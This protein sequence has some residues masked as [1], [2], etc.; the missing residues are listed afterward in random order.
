MART[1]LRYHTN[2]LWQ[3]AL[4]SSPM[5]GR[6]KREL[7]ANLLHRS[8]ALRV[9]ESLRFTDSL[10]VLNYHRVLDPRDCRYDRAVISASPDQFHEQIS[11]F[12]SRF[13]VIGL[14][15]L[16][17]QVESGKPAVGFRTMITFD[18][19][20]VD[21]YRNAF[22]VL[23]AA[24]LPA[25]FFLTTSYIGTSIVPWW[26]Q[27]ADLLRRSRNRRI[28]LDY[29][30]KQTFSLEEA[31]LD[32]NIRLVLNLYKSPAC[33]DSER[34]LAML[35]REC[36]VSRSDAAD[37]PLFLNWDQARE[38]LAGGMSIGSHTPS[39]QILSKLSEEGQVEELSKSKELLE[40]NLQIRLTALAIPVGALHAFND[41]TERAL[42]Q[43]RYQVA[44]SF[45]GGVNRGN[46]LRR[47]DIRRTGVEGKMS[48]ARVR[49]TVLQAATMGRI[50]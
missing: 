36:G 46:A 33:Q 8:G 30:E 44:F 31:C 17:G 45:Y 29:P 14:P 7:I 15:E 3:A 27:I 50:W 49:F 4:V 25:V 41:G 21:N 34:F 22:P 32:D 47:F 12:K 5:F 39:P 24:G 1:E 43:T 28:S 48:F 20:Y 37:P 40:R 42:R 2:S 11:Y 18:D 16:V 19:G 23:R 38:M 10:L 26:D 13:R 9:L 35:E 6:G